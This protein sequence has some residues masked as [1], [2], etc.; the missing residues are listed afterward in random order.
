MGA[1]ETIMEGSIYNVEQI[2]VA[3]KLTPAQNEVS[4]EQATLLYATE[5]VEEVLSR[6]RRVKLFNGRYEPSNF[7]SFPLPSGDSAIGRLIPQRGKPVDSGEFFC[8]VSS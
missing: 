3:V 7:F 6:A 1:E 2:V 4:L 8:N 5:D